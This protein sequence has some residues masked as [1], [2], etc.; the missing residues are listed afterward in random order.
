MT[1]RGLDT[2]N[3][4]EG[5]R[6]RGV[7]ILFAPRGRKSMKVTMVHCGGRKMKADVLDLFERVKEIAAVDHGV[8]VEMERICWCEPDNLRALVNDNVTQNDSMLLICMKLDGYWFGEFKLAASAKGLK[9]QVIREE[10]VV[11][12]RKCIYQQMVWDIVNKFF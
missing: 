12:K 11:G 9:K 1:E 2:L 8:D 7:G 10:N 5:K 4:M 6:F 3:A